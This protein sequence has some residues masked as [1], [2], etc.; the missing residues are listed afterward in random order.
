MLA[1]SGL[2][3]ANT[4]LVFR[5]LFAP[6]RPLSRLDLVAVNSVC[7]LL[8][9]I[10]FKA[11]LAYRVYTHHRRDRIDLITIGAWLAATAAVM[12]ATLAVPVAAS[13]WRARIDA[14]WWLA[15]VGGTAL[16]ALALVALGRAVRRVAPAQPG[17]P[18]ILSRLLCG[19]AMLASPRAVFSAV[20]LRALDLAVTAARFALAAAICGVALPLDQAVLAAA[21][22]FFFQAT[23]PAGV[24]GVREGGTA[25]LMNFLGRDDLAVVI[26]TVS[27]AE[28]AMNIA[29]GVTGWAWLRRPPRNNP[30]CPPSSSTAPSSTAP[31]SPR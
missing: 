2:T 17:T 19:A 7:S 20:T 9:Y 26:L 11:S 14:L 23:A 3:I 28:G 4:G 12:L 22:Y 30:P 18:T 8:S 24:A 6:I 5:A 1:L 29:M 15:A 10:P 25:A 31:T 13:W 27:I 21:T 16:A